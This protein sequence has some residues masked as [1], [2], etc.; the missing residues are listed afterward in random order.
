MR[1]WTEEDI[2]FL[3]TNV[4]GF[5][6]AQLGEKLNRTIPAIRGKRLHL[7]LKKKINMGQ[8]E[9]LPVPPKEVLEELY[10]TDTLTPSRIAEINQVSSTT[11]RRWLSDYGI[12]VKRPFTSKAKINIPEL[13]K[14]YLAGLVDGD[15][16]ITASKYKRKQPKK[17]YGAHCDVAII[18]TYRDFADKIKEMIGGDIQT[19]S[20][21]D[22]RE[23]KKGYRIAMSNQRSRL[24]FLE[25]IEPYLILKKERAQ[26]MIEYINSRLGARAI[27]GNATPISDSEWSLVED[28]RRLHRRN[29][30]DKNRHD[31]SV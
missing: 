11:V 3:Q 23:K 18:T 30:N 26:K 19:F 28:I 17:G 29:H 21:R 2:N 14:A 4:D 7:K 8:F 6:D 1:S 22:S 9:K 5:T 27:K 16:T 24:A 12:P 15:D 10:L 25:I 20:Y 13:D 31:N